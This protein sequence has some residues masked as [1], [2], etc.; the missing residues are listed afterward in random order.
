[1]Q[2]FVK[3]GEVDEDYVVSTDTA[4][5]VICGRKPGGIKLFSSILFIKYGSL[6]KLE[7]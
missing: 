6:L 5:L 3:D 2:Y 4:G 7:Y 1:M